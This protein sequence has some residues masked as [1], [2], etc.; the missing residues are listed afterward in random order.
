[1]YNDFHRN[2]LIK[3]QGGP[4]SLA[5][6]LLFIGGGKPSED[7][8]LQRSIRKLKLAVFL[9][10]VYVIMNFNILQEN[11]LDIGGSSQTVT[12]YYKHFLRRD[13][14]KWKYLII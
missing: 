13:E 12:V 11:W 9:G 1:M 7:N 5:C 3:E 6:T 10:E 2:A 8:T 4:R 14:S